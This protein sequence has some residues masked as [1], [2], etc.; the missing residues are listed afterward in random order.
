LLSYDADFLRPSKGVKHFLLSVMLLATCLALPSSAF[1][2]TNDPDAGATVIPPPPPPI[3]PTPPPPLP[4]DAAKTTTSVAA[5]TTSG[6]AS[7][8]A[9]ASDLTG[10][11]N[12]S[13]LGASATDEWRFSTHGYFRAPLRMGLGSRPACDAGMMPNTIKGVGADID[14]DG[15]PDQFKVPCAGPDQGTINFHSALVPDDQYLDWRYT[16]QWEKDWSEVFLNFGN[17]KIVGTVGFQAYNLTDAAFNNSSAQLGIAQA[18]VTITPDL[19]RKD[20]RLKW[21]VG[22]FWDK[23]GMAG[24]YDAGKYDTYLFGRTHLMGE[25][26]EGELDYKAVTFKLSHGLGAKLEQGSFGPGFTFVNHLHGGVAWKQKIE[27]GLHM[28]H[29]MAADSRAVG[30]GLPGDGSMFVFGPE[31]RF[32][33]GLF[34]E[35]Y[36]GFSH[37]GASHVQAVGPGVEVIHSLGGGAV[38]GANGLVDNY[39]G[40]CGACV[41]ND[42][43]MGAINTI[44]LQY[45]YSFGALWR[46]LKDPNSP[47]FW[48]EGSDVRLSVFGMMNFVDSRDPKQDGNV[49][50]KYGMDVVYTPLPWFGV[51]MRGDV[52]QPQS[53][54]QGDIAGGAGPGGRPWRGSE[55]SFG[56]LSPKAI[57]RTHFV[58]HEEVTIQYSHYFYGKAVGPQPNPFTPNP[59]GVSLPPDENVL[60]IKVTFWW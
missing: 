16:R 36:A 23:Y 12:A 31:I 38:S 25:T 39:L 37:V 59:A 51:G 43:G 57:V 50:L 49:K 18:Y 58:S 2:Q 28:I 6:A 1:A 22:A 40:T 17:N 27:G 30:A 5:P 45:D 48:G 34:G 41:L 32:N 20:V 15:Q 7:L 29:S 60:G 54:N 42:V 52:V 47:G 9:G 14:G 8:P 3:A 24:K 10:T 33:G 56:V 4:D 46:K 53:K 13:A 44:E 26:L 35:L 19:K 21:K 55:Y 11:P